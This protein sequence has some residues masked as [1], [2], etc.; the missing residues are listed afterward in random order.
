MGKWDSYALGVDVSHYNGSIDAA[1]MRQ[2]GVS[3]L[4][5]KCGDGKQITPGS[6]Y[7]VA[8]Y[9]DP[10]FSDNVQQAYDAGIPCG[11]YFYFQPGV[12]QGKTAA[13]DFQYQVL[14]YAMRNKVAGKSFHFLVIDIEEKTNTN[15]NT[16]DMI[17]TFADWIWKDA[18]FNSVPL[19]FYTSVGYLNAYPALRDWLAYPADPK[20]MWYAQWVYPATPKIQTTWAELKSRYYPADTAKV[21]NYAGWRFW[22]WASCFY[23]MEGT[24][25]GEID[26]N[27]YNGTVEQL[28]TWLKFAPQGQ[29]Q[30]QPEPE[31]EPQPEP[32]D[33]SEVHAKLDRILARLEGLK[34]LERS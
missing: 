13:D 31:P 25:N 1:R 2:G 11:A 16:R 8:N 33:L 28:Y 3:F 20:E 24:G 12:P 9:V 6:A 32:V 17:Q 22:Q 30:P 15:T 27:F 34:W 5:A 7:D 18:Q 10:R 19:L 23:K 26:L 14:K 4:I 21:Q 29:P